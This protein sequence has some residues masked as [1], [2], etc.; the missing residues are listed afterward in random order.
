MKERRRG[1]AAFGRRAIIC[2]LSA[3]DWRSNETHVRKKPLFM[4]GPRGL[5]TQNSAKSNE[6]KDR[7]NNLVSWPSMHEVRKM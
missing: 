4:E 1:A 3:I 2:H 7:C 6:L 5:S